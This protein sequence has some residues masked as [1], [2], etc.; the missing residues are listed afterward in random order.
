MFRLTNKEP[1]SFWQG[2]E[3]KLFCKS[4]YISYISTSQVQQKYMINHNQEVL[5]Y[6][7]QTLNNDTLKMSLN[8]CYYK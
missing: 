1:S 7:I 3:E 5:I 6:I 2:T 4:P 8:S